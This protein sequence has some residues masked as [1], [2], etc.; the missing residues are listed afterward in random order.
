ML[1]M[2]ED[3]AEAAE[4]FT[5]AAVADFMEAVAA[6]FT[7]VEDSPAGGALGSAEGIRLADLVAASMGD[8]VSMAAAAGL[9][10]A[11]EAS[12][13]AAE[14]GADEAGAGAVGAGDL[15]LAGRIGDMDGAIRMATTG[16]ARGIMRP[17]VTM[18][19]RPAGLRTT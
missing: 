8:A 2:V 10:G 1:S 12:A 4:V 5:V 13:G 15:D 16:T 14:V 9:A 3:T 18:V 11:A 6:D 7:A 17:T 19:T